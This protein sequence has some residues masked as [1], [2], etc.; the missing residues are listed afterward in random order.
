MPKEFA[1]HLLKSSEKRTFTF[2]KNRYMKLTILSV[3]FSFLLLP[4]VNKESYLIVGTYDSPK[5]E[6]IYVYKFNSTDGTVQEVSHIKTSNPSYVVVSPDEKFVYAVH[7]NAKAGNGGEVA[8]FS[9]DKKQGTLSFI[10]QQLSGGDHPCYVTIDKTGKWVF[11]ANYTSGSLAVLPVNKD[12][13]LGA[14]TTKIQNEGTGYN[15][16][17]QAGPHVHCTVLSSDNR[18][19]FV[20]DLGLDKVMIYAFDAKTGK[21][22]PAKT[23]FSK[24]VD[25]SGPRHLTF[26]PTNKYAYL[27]EEMS[28]TVEAYQY[29]NGTLKNIQRISTLPAGD[30]GLIGSADIHV[31][32]DGKFLYASNRGKGNSNT[33][34]IFKI[35]TSNGML[36]SVGHQ[37]TMGNIPRNFNF[38]PSGNFLLVANQESNEVVIFKRNIQTGLLT[39][40]G[41]R[42]EVGKPV[43]IKWIKSS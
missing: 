25:G 41:K 28:G 21:L 40:T 5:S 29:N 22:T 35:N 34:A 19:L 15:K 27:I 7:E 37:Y 1:I 31:S 30:T 32:Q 24:S 14:A 43:C 11:D 20:S 39:D 16:Q 6:G 12:G 36:T 17:R 18:W 2:V 10:N 4:S 38:D 9:F 33:I 8:A 42:I 13:S 23:P 26:H 3:L